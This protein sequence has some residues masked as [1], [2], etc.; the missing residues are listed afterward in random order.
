MNKSVLIGGIVVLI[1]G[2]VAYFLWPKPD[3]GKDPLSLIEGY[4]DQV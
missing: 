3:K 1:G 4:H 2:I